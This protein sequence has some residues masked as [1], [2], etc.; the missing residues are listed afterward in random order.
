[1]HCNESPHKTADMLG[2]RHGLLAS[3]TQSTVK[4]GQGNVEARSLPDLSLQIQNLT[5][6]GFLFKVSYFY[7]TPFL[8]VCK[9]R[10]RSQDITKHKLWRMLLMLPNVIL[11]HNQ[12]MHCTYLDYFGCLK[13]TNIHAKYKTIKHQD[14]LRSGRLWTALQRQAVYWNYKQYENNTFDFSPDQACQQF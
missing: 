13:R 8:S 12:M 5:F 4:A 3:R 6:F 11:I 7:N 1:M 10:V 14:M 2:H 9:R